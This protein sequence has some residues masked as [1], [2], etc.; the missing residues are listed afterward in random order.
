MVPAPSWTFKTRISRTDILRSLS[1]L[2]EYPTV[3]V[4]HRISRRLLP[5]G[6]WVTPGQLAGHLD[7]VVQ[8]GFSFLTPDDFLSSISGAQSDQVL[9]TFDDGTEDI[10]EHRYLFLERDI[11]P[12][13]FVPVDCL[14]RRNTWEWP[15]PGRRTMHLSARQTAKLADLGWEIGLHGASHGDL[16]RLSPQQWQDEIGQARQRLGDITGHPVRLFSYPFGRTHGALAAEVAAQGFTIAFTMTEA[17]IDVDPRFS[18][19][20]RPIYCIDTAADVLAKLRD[21]RGQSWS[22]RWQRWREHGAHGVGRWTARW[23]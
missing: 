23:R 20:R 3:L 21:P 17:P 14:G 7:A 12:V 5:A 22:G 13:V 11:R 15:I 1:V 4:Y 8:S 9:L 18:W 6:T 16:T 19:R 10:Y 2:P